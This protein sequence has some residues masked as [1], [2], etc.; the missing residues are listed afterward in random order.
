MRA[1]SPQRGE[2]WGEG[3]LTERPYPLTPALSPLGR[4]R[5]SIQR[6]DLDDR[7][8]VVAADPQ[9]AGVLGVVDEDAA[10]IGRPR[11]RVFG[12]LPGLDVEA[13]DPVG[14][15]RGGPGIA[16][17]VGYRVIRRRP[18][19]RHFP[20]LDLAGLRVEHADG[21]AEIFGEPQPALV[22]D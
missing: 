8:A 3:A 18:R 19:C 12:V 5:K 14:V 9:R 10:D 20:F 11:Q 13:R 7:S 16:V 22:V 1:P 2:G 6:L 17:L 4:G 21:I 15:H